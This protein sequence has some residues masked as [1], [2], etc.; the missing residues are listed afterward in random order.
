MALRVRRVV[1]NGKQNRIKAS[2]IKFCSTV[3]TLPHFR[4]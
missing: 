3:M 2:K 1:L 4:R